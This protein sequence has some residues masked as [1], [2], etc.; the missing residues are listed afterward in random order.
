MVPSK[1]YLIHTHTKYQGKKLVFSSIEMT[2]QSLRIYHYPFLL[3]LLLI[4]TMALVVL[5]SDH[6]LFPGIQVTNAQTLNLPEPTQNSGPIQKSSGNM[7]SSPSSQSFSE[8][9]NSKYGFKVQYPS[10]WQVISHTNSSLFPSINCTSSDVMVPY[11][12]S[13]RHA[14]RECK[15]LLLLVLKI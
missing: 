13:F 9:N 6:R 10:N 4:M 1:A 5:P 7:S 14:S 8:Y 12:N 2:L 11:H 3:V 15:V